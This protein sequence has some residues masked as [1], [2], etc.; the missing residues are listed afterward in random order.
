M[1]FVCFVLF[2]GLLFGQ[3]TEP[4]SDTPASKEQKESVEDKQVKKKSEKHIIEKKK[5]KAKRVEREEIKI[6]KRVRILGRKPQPMNRSKKNP[7]EADT[8][9]KQL[10]PTSERPKKMKKQEE[11]TPAKNKSKQ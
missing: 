3:T 6:E 8:V 10:K 7:S 9:D 5:K 1:I 4:K 11:K 2:N